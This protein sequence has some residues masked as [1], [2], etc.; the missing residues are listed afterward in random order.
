MLWIVIPLLFRLR[1]VGNLSCMSFHPKVLIFN[2]TL[3]P[4][5][6]FHIPSCDSVAESIWDA[7]KVVSFFG[8]HG[9]EEFIISFVSFAVSV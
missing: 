5:I 8:K 9:D 4:Q 7:Q 2:G 3:T 1:R 6:R